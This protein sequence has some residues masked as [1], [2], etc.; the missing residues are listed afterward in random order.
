MDHIFSPWRMAYI[1][2]EKST[3]HCVFCSALGQEDSPENLIIYRGQNNF[4]ILNR[5]PYT[6]GHLMVLPLEHKPQ[7]DSVDSATRSE[8]MELTTR[9]TQVLG[10]IYHPQGFNIGINLGAAAGAGIEEHLHMHIV[11]RWFGD[12][13]YMTAVGKTRVMPEALEESWR[14]IT[15]IWR[16]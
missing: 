10:D 15:A 13:N 2:S 12:T 6:S 9:A 14:R 5:F 1:Q 3:T 11:P 4:V 7:L 16:A 8:L